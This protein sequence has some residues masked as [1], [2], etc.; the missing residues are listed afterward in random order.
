MGKA[1]RQ[2]QLCSSSYDSDSSD[3]SDDEHP[4]LDARR[5][6]AADMQQGLQTR[7]VAGHSVLLSWDPDISSNCITH[8]ALAAAAD[9]QSYS[10]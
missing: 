9:Q 7:C 8:C 2:S 4:A 6:Q 3:F 1:K 5:Y 10:G